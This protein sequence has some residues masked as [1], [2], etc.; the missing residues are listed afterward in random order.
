MH[1]NRQLPMWTAKKNKKRS[2][3]NRTGDLIYSSIGINLSISA[4]FDVIESDRVS[5][6][7]RLSNTTTMDG[8]G[9]VLLAPTNLIRPL[10]KSIG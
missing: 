10:R 5:H 2:P 4:Y 8:N 9:A 6:S 3:S 1:P 7:D